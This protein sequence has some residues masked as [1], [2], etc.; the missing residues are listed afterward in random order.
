MVHSHIYVGQHSHSANG[1]ETI[2]SLSQLML[3]SDSQDSPLPFL[4]LFLLVILAL[5]ALSGKLA[6]G[7]RGI[8][9]LRAPPVML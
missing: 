2:L 5:P 1:F 3:T 9:S 4:L 6:V 8:L 7:E